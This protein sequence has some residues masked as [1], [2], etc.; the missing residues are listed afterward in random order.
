MDMTSSRKQYLVP[1]AAVTCYLG[2][3]AAS[4]E[5]QNDQWRDLGHTMSLQG[6]P[7]ISGLLKLSNFFYPLIYCT[8]I[9]LHIYILIQIYY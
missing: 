8:G 3:L 9:Q 7:Q 4:S 1:T 5:L 2:N 6:V